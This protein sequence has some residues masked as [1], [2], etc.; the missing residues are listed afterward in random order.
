MV[1]IT[2]TI[3]R[4]ILM[5]KWKEK[6][7]REIELK[8]LADST[9]RAYLRNVT[10]LV[11]FYRKEPKNITLEDIKKYLHHF[12]NEIAAGR[13]TKRAASSVNNA[14]SAIRFFYLTVYKRNYSGALPRMKSHQKAPLVLSQEEVKSMIDSIH[15]VFYKAV[16]MTLYS[17]GMRQSE[18]RNLQITDIDSKRMVIYIRNGKGLKD[19]QA[20]LSP[21]LLKCLRTYWRLFRI[22]MAKSDYLFIGTKNYFNGK[23]GGRLSHTTVGYIVDKAAEVAGI[24][25]KVHPHCLRH[26]FAVHLVE[27]GVHFRHIQ[28]LLGHSNPKNTSRYTSVADISKIKVPE[29]IDGLINKE[30]K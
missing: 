21:T 23:L 30:R 17:T 16:L 7:I 26:S 20:S 8:G 19:R 24:K 1:V 11:G 5:E 29:L 6:F 25:K 10:R 12:Q 9:K 4:R 27:K 22:N 15:S 14:A 3:S 28:Y 2:S 18:L 13:T